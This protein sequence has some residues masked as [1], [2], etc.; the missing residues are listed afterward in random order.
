MGEPDFFTEFPGLTEGAA[1]WLTARKVKLLGIEQPS[2]HAVHHVEVHKALLS[3]GVVLIESMVNLD[4]LTCD[5]VYIAALP[6]NLE[7]L[8]GAPVRAIAIE[9]IEVNE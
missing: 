9:G 7:G 6:I 8:D 1:K 5:R 4:L 2:V 3:Y